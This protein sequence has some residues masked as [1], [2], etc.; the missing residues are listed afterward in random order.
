MN[1]RVRHGA[2]FF[3]TYIGDCMHCSYVYLI[4]KK[5]EALNCFRHYLNK[6][7]NQL[8]KKS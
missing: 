7:Q 5:L 8:G 3:I 4:S 6:V 2:P 1:V